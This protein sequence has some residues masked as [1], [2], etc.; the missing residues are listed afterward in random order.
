MKI[1]MC[2][3]HENLAPGGHPVE[4]SLTRAITPMVA[5]HCIARGANASV[6]T[7]NPDGT[8]TISL[9]GRANKVLA[10]NEQ[11]Q[12]DI[13]LEIHA[14][15]NS[16][17]DAGRGCF[18]VFPDSPEQN[19]TDVHVRDTLGPRIARAIRDM[20]SIPLRGNGTLSEKKTAVGL[21][22]GRL[23]VFRI[24]RPIRATCR[25]LIVEVGAFSSPADLAILQ[26]PQTPDRMGRAIAQALVPEPKT[27]AA[28]GTAVLF[29]RDFGIPQQWCEEERLQRGLGR[30]K[31][32]EFTHAGK[33]WQLFDHGAISWTET[34]GAEVHRPAPP[35]VE[36]AAP[37]VE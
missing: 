31:S 18:V 8:I 32:P 20:T 36:Q 4:R 14:E 2:A 23:A 9:E 17:G 33:T 15:H 12:V 30:A 16:A 29:N 19:D 7:P 13:F 25:R 22:G 11:T 35:D 24:T 21:G 27:P 5:L 26:Q 28:W 34:T 1:L 37:E 3:G 6:V 10:I